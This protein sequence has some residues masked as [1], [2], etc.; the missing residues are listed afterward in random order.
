MNILF[1][2]IYSFVYP[3]MFVYFG[4]MAFNS[5]YDKHLI[6]P[7]RSGYR[8]VPSLLY[9]LSQLLPVF[10]FECETPVQCGFET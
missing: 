5:R 8:H 2:V 7:V 9:V 4:A 3:H 1:G 10:G 6:R